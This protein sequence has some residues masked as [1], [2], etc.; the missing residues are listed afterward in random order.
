M[1][2]STWLRLVLSQVTLFVLLLL[3]PGHTCGTGR[4]GYR[5]IRNRKMTPLVFR[6]Y[7]PNVSENTL[8]ASGMAEGA[9]KRGTKRFDELVVNYNPE[10]IFKDEEGTG[11]DRIMSQVSQC[12]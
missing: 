4:G 11:A 2:K 5:R 6:Q 9:I 12:H 10:I 1:C 8:G 3:D 7:I